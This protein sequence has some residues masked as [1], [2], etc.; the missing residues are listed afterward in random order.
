M[1]GLYYFV[2][3]AMSE[4]WVRF[5]YSK[6]LVQLVCE[7]H[8]EPDESDRERSACQL[9][10]RP[11]QVLLQFMGLLSWP[12]ILIIN[13]IES[14]SADQVSLLS[15]CLS[16]QERD[17]PID[18]PGSIILILKKNNYLSGDLREFVRN[19]IGDD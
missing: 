18:W 14:L 16:F 2:R 10:R 9:A 15:G 5:G 7:D 3:V 1:A 19:V 12:K 11:Y 4:D 13:H 8:A 17:R 6:L